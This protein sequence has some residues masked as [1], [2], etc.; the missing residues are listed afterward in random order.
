MKREFSHFDVDNGRVNNKNWAK[1][2]PLTVRPLLAD[3][4]VE[5]VVAENVVGS[6][7]DLSSA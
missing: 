4:E 5:G 6:C 1:S 7:T 2:L 3:V